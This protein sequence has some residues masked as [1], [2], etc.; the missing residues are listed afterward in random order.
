MKINKLK[1]TLLLSSILFL[2]VSSCTKDQRYGNKLEGSWI[3][4][5]KEMSNENVDIT[6][7]IIVIEFGD[8]IISGD[9]C[10]G[11]YRQKTLNADN[12][13]TQLV[14]PIETQVTDR[15]KTLNIDYNYGANFETYEI[16]ELNRKSLVIQFENE[17]A[18]YSFEP[19]K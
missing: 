13:V 16:L 9:N 4:I 17:G 11:I 15:G 18:I 8:C 1:Q 5:K 19:V 14:L 3:L 2:V 12:T 7:L 6:G 10:S